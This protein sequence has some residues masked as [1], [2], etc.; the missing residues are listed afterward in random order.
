MF[1]TAVAATVAVAGVGGHLLLRHLGG[2]PHEVNSELIA[3]L[4]RQLERCGPAQ[5]T[6]AGA[7]GAPGFRYLASA[8]FFVAGLLAGAGGAFL[9]LRVKR[10]RPE[11]AAPVSAAAVPQTPS[12]RRLQD[13]TAARGGF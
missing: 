6:C 2:C 9:V 10:S 1:E 4:S 12:Q 8:G 3:L 11:E 7:E 13:G 5:L